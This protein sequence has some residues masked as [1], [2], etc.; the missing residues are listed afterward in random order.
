MSLRILFRCDCG[1][2]AGYGHFSRCLNLARAL[3]GTVPAPRCVFWGSY[4]DFGGNALA[5]YG[6]ERL[7]AA[8]GGFSAADVA[9]TLEAT[10]DFDL[11]VL[12]SYL[13]D[14]D[15]VDG[16]KKRRC[17]LVV[18]DDM[19]R[20]DLRDADLAICFRAGSQAFP[21]GA[22]REAL[23]LEYLVVKPELRP[24]RERNLADSARPIR[25]ALV[26][27]SGGEHDAARLK[28]AVAAVGAALPD[29]AVIY[30][31]RDGRPLPGLGRATPTAPRVDV[32]SLYA[33]ADLIITGGGLV[34]YES[35]YCAIP[36]ASLSQTELQGEDTRVLAAQDLTLDLGSWSAFDPGAAS[37]ALARFAADAGAVERQRRA[38]RHSLVSDSPQRL[39]GVLLGL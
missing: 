36:N 26:F 30:V 10:R 13:A 39:A 29:A 19:R 27:F 38:F 18:L 37:G 35:A 34:K 24:L 4:D 33:Q 21:Y 28:D 32:E 22:R 15:Y 23:G 20:L 5:R 31:T 7:P 12:D 16:L 6:I 3:R 17:R 11:L 2:A 1:T 8:V 14:Q 9:P 25:A